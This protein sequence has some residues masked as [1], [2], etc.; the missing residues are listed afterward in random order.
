[1][2][3]LKKYLRPFLVSVALVLVLLMVQALCDLNL[4][5]Y[6]SDIVNVGIQQ[7]G[8]ENAAPIQI[9]SQGMAFI[10]SVMTDEQRDLVNQS[11]QLQGEGEAASFA[12]GK[13][14]AEQ[15]AALNTA[16]EDAAAMLIVAS[17]SQG[18]AK[19]AHETVQASGNN[20]I[21]Q[22]VGAAS[23]SAS[24]DAE[25]ALD[26]AL[27]ITKFYSYTQMIEDMPDEQLAPLRAQVAEIA[28]TM[29]KQYGVAM[30]ESY[31]REL[32]LDIIGIQRGYI[33]NIGLRML[34]IAL[35][36]GIATV[37]VGL[38]SSRIAA[39]V[40]RKLRSDVFS[41]VESFSS[42]ELNKFGAA[43]LIT[44]TT[45]DIQQIQALLQM[46][47]RIILYAPIMCV[48]GIIMAVGKSPSMSWIIAVAGIALLGL[49]ALLFSIVVPRFNRIQKLLDKL[50][51]VSREN[52]S[53]LMVIRAFGTREHEEA[54]YDEVNT[55][56]TK[57]NL[58]VNRVM[59]LMGPVMT[60]VMSGVS[61]LTVWVGAHQVAASTIQVGD[62]M[63]FMQYA[64]Q[65]IMSFVMMSIMFVML[66]RAQVSATRIADVLETIPAIQDP[67]SPKPFDP[68]KKGV[69]EFRDVSFKYEGA[70]EYA[71][72]DMSFTALPGQTTALIGSTGSGKS[73]AA[74]MI[75][76]FFDATK[77][78]VL[79]D[80]VDVRDVTQHDLREKIGFVP[81]KGI[82]LSGTIASNICY[83]N[84]DASEE[85]MEDSARVA[86]ALDFIEQKP[87]G[88]D[89][90]IAQGGDNVSG[91]QK[92]R[93]SIARALA[94]DPEIFVF[95]DSFSALD[96]K[97]D[98]TLR[99]ALREHTKDA[100]IIIVAQRVST[101][102]N[103]EQ[104]IVMDEG[105]I[106]GKG[107]HKELLKTCDQ[108]REIA[109]SQ[110]SEEE[111]A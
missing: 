107:T 81:Q 93:L 51:L 8:I 48:G 69:V 50:N 79:V 36:G 7:N 29:K 74:N 109:S 54:R 2:L 72:T 104:I 34:L 60:L 39:G 78:E 24:Q 94:K 100:T 80:G 86:Q 59:A 56:L 49:I 103:A 30:T 28:P 52:L 1:M 40:A 76:R 26:E 90:I 84:P 16:F 38:L 89:D 33:I 19:P 67:P 95:D 73:T 96:F 85:Q 71:L 3:R 18:G 47:I 75:V 20:E 58:F 57:V 5:N 61:L 14:D 27:D 22:G 10:Q 98:V 46:G 4:P 111:L 68:S 35:L 44:R 23:N 101:I 55:D 87:N 105:H 21:P 106:V 32:D 37:L 92:Q 9:S 15:Q 17:Q 12:L 66:P 43:S 91:G 63:A 45:N 102:L 108:Y 97:T 70:E 6:M 53:G 77:G 42:A 65:I 99:K 31:Y 62:M 64:T 110:L 88:F 13:P 25:Q 11:Y 41:K 82:L 83:G